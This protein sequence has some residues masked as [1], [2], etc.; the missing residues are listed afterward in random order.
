[1][2]IYAE[3][4]EAGDRKHAIL[5]I[6]LICDLDGL[7]MPKQVDLSLAQG[8]AA[9][10]VDVKQLDDMADRQREKRLGGGRNGK[11]KK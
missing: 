9:I 3:A 5:A 2:D 11:E 1:M 10:T 7:I 6:R 8:P 4:R